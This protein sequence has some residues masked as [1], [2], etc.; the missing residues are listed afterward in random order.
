[1]VAKLQQ[2]NCQ[3]KFYEFKII[4]AGH[5][6][7]QDP[8]TGCQPW[9]AEVEDVAYANVAYIAYEIL[10]ISLTELRYVY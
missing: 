6:F 10:I 8:E 3:D 5:L 4:Q 2:S 1:M 7:K 9:R